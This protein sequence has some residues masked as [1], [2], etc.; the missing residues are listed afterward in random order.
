MEN[1]ALRMKALELALASQH[2][3]VVDTAAVVTTAQSYYEFLTKK[4]DAA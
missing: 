2:G 4:S 3:E 1:E